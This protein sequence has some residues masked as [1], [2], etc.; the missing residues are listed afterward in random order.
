MITKMSKLVKKSPDAQTLSSGARVERLLGFSS[1]PCMLVLL[2]S[3]RTEPCEVLR[4]IEVEYFE[5]FD[6]E[7]RFELPVGNLCM[8]R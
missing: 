8:R 2:N 5:R 4:A 3:F 6:E 1:K 7:N